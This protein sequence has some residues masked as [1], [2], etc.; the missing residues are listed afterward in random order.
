MAHY[1]H[2]FLLED[3]VDTSPTHLPSAIASHNDNSSSS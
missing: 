2:R 1:Q 3:N